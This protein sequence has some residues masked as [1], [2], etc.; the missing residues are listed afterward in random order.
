MSSETKKNSLGLG[1]DI[2]SSSHRSVGDTTFSMTEQGSD[3]RIREVPSAQISRNN[4]GDKANPATT[5]TSRRRLWWKLYFAK[6]WQLKVVQ[7]ACAIYIAIMSYA[8]DAAYIID[9]E[10]EENTRN[11]VILKDGTERAIVADNLYCV[12][13]QY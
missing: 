12:S 10:S 2:P 8:P 4:K 9:E 7:F 6:Y 5:G 13:L 3:H 1:G 11:G